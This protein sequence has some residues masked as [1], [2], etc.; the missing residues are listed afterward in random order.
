MSTR[1]SKQR[2]L[3]HACCAPCSTVPLERL[4]SEYD[5]AVLF[6]GPNIH[7]RAEYQLRL[8]D[9]RKLCR[10]LGVEL[11]ETDYRP[12]EWGRSIAPFRKLP[13]GSQ[14]CQA[15]FQLRMEQTASIADQ[16]GFDL[17]TVT[18]T[19]SRHKNSKVLERIGR[20]VAENFKVAYLA[21]DLKKENG[22]NISVQRSREF[23]LR[24]Q[25]YCG[26]SLSLS[27]AIKRRKKSRAVDR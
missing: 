16:H 6:Y 3:I 11:I 4:E 15:C 26:C 18:L 2:L 5:L 10:Q 13:E 21:V 24:R 22:Y 23:E 7:P 14:R 27:E 8:A 17:F 12:A 25:D 1:R 9:Q 19:V 20:Q